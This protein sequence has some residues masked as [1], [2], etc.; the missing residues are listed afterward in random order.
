MVRRYGICVSLRD[1]DELS[2]EEIDDLKEIFTLSNLNDSNDGNKNKN[3]KTKSS[4]LAPYNTLIENE[5]YRINDDGDIDFDNGELFVA[6][7]KKI[8]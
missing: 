5:S 3:I 7:Y 2:Q 4:I 8:L 1:L 6:R